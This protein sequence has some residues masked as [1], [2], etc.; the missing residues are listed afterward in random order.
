M[1][2]TRK[3]GANPTPRAKSANLK[4]GTVPP[5]QRRLRPRRSC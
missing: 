3:S 2:F 4:T 1:V 5:N